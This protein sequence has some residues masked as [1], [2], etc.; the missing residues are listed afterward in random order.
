MQSEMVGQE[1]E[2]PYVGSHEIRKLADAP[3]ERFHPQSPR[4]LL[5]WMAHQSVRSATFTFVVSLEGRLLLSARG[6]EHVALAQG[7]NVR[8]AGEI[9]LAVHRDIIHVTSVTNQSTGYCPEPSCWLH[10]KAA[11]EAAGLTPTDGFTHEFHFRRC[12]RCHTIN[13]L[14]P[15]FP[16]CPVCGEQLPEKWNLR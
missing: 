12:T 5:E 2:Y 3:I 8:G 1:H 4:E 13:L 9:S 10:V 11:L 7:A 16:D 14:K 6:T 15:E